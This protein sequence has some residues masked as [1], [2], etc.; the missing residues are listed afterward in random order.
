MRR[1]RPRYFVK[2]ATLRV[3]LWLN[4]KTGQKISDF[5]FCRWVATKKYEWLDRYLDL[6]PRK[7][8]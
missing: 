8:R 4:R 2:E 7:D 5:C 1:R 3:L 6:T